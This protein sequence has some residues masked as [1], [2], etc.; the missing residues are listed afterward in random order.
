MA[1]FV[2]YV[3]KDHIYLNYVGTCYCSNLGEV[4]QVDVKMTFLH[5]HSMK[6]LHATTWELDHEHQI[7]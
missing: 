7:C 1:C 6:K 2:G 5:G 4:D 3:Y